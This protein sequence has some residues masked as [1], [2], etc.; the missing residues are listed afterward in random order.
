M[1]R[2]DEDGKRMEKVECIFFFFF[3]SAINLRYNYTILLFFSRR[4]K[5]ENSLGTIVDAYLEN[6]QCGADC[7][8]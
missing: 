8:I 3:H 4:R 5:L 6:L 2:Y 1:K 7:R